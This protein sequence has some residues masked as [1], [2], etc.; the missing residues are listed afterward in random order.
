[1]TDAGI[2]GKVAVVGMAVRVPGAGRDLKSFWHNIERGVESISVFERAE[3]EE[4]GVQPDVLDEPG[5]VPARAVV[6]DATAFDA[7]LFG[8]SPAEAALTDP[9][10][11][12]LLEC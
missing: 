1:M 11:R 8:F 4:W 7:E 12:I 10:Q 9:Q 3:L 5:F 2:D 6:K